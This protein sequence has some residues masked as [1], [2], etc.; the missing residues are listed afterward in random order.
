MQHKTSPKL[1]VCSAL[2]T[3]KTKGKTF[4]EAHEELIGGDFSAAEGLICPFL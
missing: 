3:K 4:E 1:L 2:L